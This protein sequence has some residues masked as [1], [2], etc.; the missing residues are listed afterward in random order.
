V[1]FTSIFGFFWRNGKNGHIMLYVPL[2][3]TSLPG[4]WINFDVLP[5]MDLCVP[6]PGWFWTVI[7][8][9]QAFLFFVAKDGIKNTYQVISTL[10]DHKYT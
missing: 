9:L 7:W 2:S 8:V 1:V 3:M 4:K 5:I 10:P 6:F